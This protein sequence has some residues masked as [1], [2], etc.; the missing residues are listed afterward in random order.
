MEDLCKYI[1]RLEPLGPAQRSARKCKSPR[2]AMSQDNQYLPENGEDCFYK[3]KF[4]IIN[5]LLIFPFGS[6]TEV[7]FGKFTQLEHH[8]FSPWKQPL[9]LFLGVVFMDFG[10]LRNSFFIVSLTSLVTRTASGGSGWGNCRQVQ[11]RQ[12]DGSER[13]LLFSRVFCSY[14]TL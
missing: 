10:R 1:F 7:S 6:T 3:G 12:R 14:F 2:I 9:R 13:V 8:S 5:P 4:P 11:L